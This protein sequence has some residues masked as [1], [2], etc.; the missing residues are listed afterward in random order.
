MFLFFQSIKPILEKRVK[1]SIYQGISRNIIISNYSE[2]IELTFVNGKI[3]NIRQ[4][5]GYPNEQECDLRI[6]GSLLFK[7]LLSDKSIEEINYIIDDA[8]VKPASKILIE[9]LFPKK[10]SY[11]D[12]YY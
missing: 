4:Y 5:K 3:A 7:L 10:V 2:N 8:I 12:T 9:V 11:P 6:P 1:D